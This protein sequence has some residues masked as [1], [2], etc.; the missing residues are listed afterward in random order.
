MS[1]NT[2]SGDSNELEALFDSIACGVS[3][4]PSAVIREPVPA[5][6]SPVAPSLM[7]QAR[8]GGGVTDDSSDL[9]ALFDTIASKKQAESVSAPVEKIADDESAWPVQDKVFQQVGQMARQLHDTLG[10]LG[11]D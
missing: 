3:S 8:E 5:V 11:Y 1:N 9:Q 10:A 6:A 7:Q 2:T 4:A